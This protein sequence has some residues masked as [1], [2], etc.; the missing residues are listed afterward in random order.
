M[1]LKGSGS[2]SADVLD[3]AV[4]PAVKYHLAG[5]FSLD[6][7]SATLRLL[8]ATGQAIGVNVG[9]FNPAMDAGLNRARVGLVPGRRAAVGHALIPWTDS[10]GIR[11][12]LRRPAPPALR[13][14]CSPASGFFP[15]RYSR[16]AGS[17]STRSARARWA[18]ITE[19][20][21]TRRWLKYRASSGHPAPGAK[22]KRPVQP[23]PPPR[24]S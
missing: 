24:A 12:G 19:R 13:W 6:E 22:A 5:G 14:R 10:V 21:A 4:M 17:R 2:T 16:R 3:H 15:S 20:S 9:I 8:M 18:F 11:D 23:G 7:L 1:V